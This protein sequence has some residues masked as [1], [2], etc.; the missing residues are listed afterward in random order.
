MKLYILYKNEV[1]T[2]RDGQMSTRSTA[3]IYWSQP[4]VPLPETRWFRSGKYYS[5][6]MSWMLREAY[7]DP[8]KIA[9]SLRRHHDVVV[10]QFEVDALARLPE[11]EL[12]DLILEGGAEAL[13]SGF[14]LVEA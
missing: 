14:Q 3:M 9:R 13:P 11:P 6:R 5:S 8:D 10:S 12:D 2:L 1:L 4:P 7:G